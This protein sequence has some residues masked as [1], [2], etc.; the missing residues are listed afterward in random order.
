MHGLRWVDASGKL[1]VSSLGHEPVEGGR[2]VNG[3]PLYVAEAR[4]N[5]VVHPGKASKEL[6]GSYYFIC[7]E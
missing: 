1:D 7:S 6:D 5:G 4:H 2:E 3:T